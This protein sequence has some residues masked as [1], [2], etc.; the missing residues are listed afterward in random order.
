[1][2]DLSGESVAGGDRRQGR[3]R[4]SW[5][6][7]VALV[8]LLILLAARFWQLYGRIYALQ[9]EQKRT[10]ARLLVDQVLISKH[11]KNL[12]AIPLDEN[13]GLPTDKPLSAAFLNVV[14]DLTDK[15]SR[16]EYD[17]SF[18]RPQEPDAVRDEFE[19]KVLRR[20]ANAKPEE[21]GDAKTPEFAERLL[22]EKNHYQYYEPIRARESCLLCHRA[23]TGESGIGPDGDRQLP[24]G[25][26]KAEAPG[27]L[28]AI[29][30]IT[31]ADEPP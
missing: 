23:P 13:S 1:M 27:D 3:N 25:K 5:P 16:Q 18:I 4:F 15:L 29:I 30:K 10:T 6:T 31:I 2:S 7:C 19:W 26:V 12:E 11:W 8:L 21:P 22:P 24:F 14:E 9:R 20:F 17:F 28:L